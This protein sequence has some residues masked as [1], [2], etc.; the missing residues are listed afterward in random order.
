MR[1]QRFCPSLLSLTR[2][3][4]LLVSKLPGEFQGAVLTENQPS[5]RKKWLI[6]SQIIFLKRLTF[7]LHKGQ[8]QDNREGR[9]SQLCMASPGQGTGPWQP[10]LIL[11]SAAALKLHWK[12]CRSVTGLYKS[13]E[14]R[15]LAQNPLARKDYQ[16]NIRLLFLWSTS[17]NW[18]LHNFFWLA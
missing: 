11:T 12:H 18:K 4:R 9:D 16:E 3:A 13:I 5:E 7:C 15:N 10:W 6:F 1:L 14:G 2:Q 8:R 17:F